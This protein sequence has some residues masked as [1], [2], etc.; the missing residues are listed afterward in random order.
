MARW[1][2]WRDIR[3]WYN[4]WL[5]RHLKNAY[6]E[7]IDAEIDECKAEDECFAGEIEQ[8]ARPSEADK[9]QALG[10]EVDSVFRESQQL[11]DLM[12][13]TAD[14]I[15]HEGPAPATSASP[16]SGRPVTRLTWFCQ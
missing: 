16:A 3:N 1:K 5:G 8:A 9:E 2:R 12:A 4:A 13:H 11:A 10:N 14:E 15:D 7:Y 6:K